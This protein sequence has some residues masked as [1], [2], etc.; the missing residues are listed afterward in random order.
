MLTKMNGGFK[1][2]YGKAAAC[3]ALALF[4]LA[5]GSCSQLLGWGVL[6]W[7]VEKPAI[8]SGNRLARL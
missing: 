5:F 1:T 6:L 2:M 3:A 7:S 4:T 8:A